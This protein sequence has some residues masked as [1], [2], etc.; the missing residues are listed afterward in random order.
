MGHR[1]DAALSGDLPSKPM[2][3]TIG[4]TAIFLTAVCIAAA[5]VFRGQGQSDFLDM[6]ESTVAASSVES[7]T[8]SALSRL[9]KAGCLIKLDY[10]YFP[11]RR[12]WKA[13]TSK[14][15]GLIAQ[16]AERYSALLTSFTDLGSFFESI[17]AQPNR[18]GGLTP[19]WLNGWFPGMDAIS[20]YGLLAKSNPRHYVEVGSGNSTMFARQAIE[21]HGLR[22]KIISIDPFPRANIDSICDQVV[23]SPCEDVPS[24]FFESLE[25]EDILFVDNSHRAFP[26]SDVT[27]F[28][29]EILQNLPKGLIYGLHDV[30]LP[31]DYPD[32]WKDR[33]YNEQYLLSA[34][35]LGGARSLGARSFSTNATLTIGDAKSS[36]LW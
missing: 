30:F 22:T 36:G 26:N 31:W 28:F 13:S 4:M 5:P 11:R 9:E 16:G 24:E 20:L 33:F 12:E 14:I 7:A 10:P 35:L 2:V 32:E 1:T 18:N 15:F 23:R 34:Y 8:E 6:N 27:V 29:T 19:A 17:S 25:S 21:D 3:T